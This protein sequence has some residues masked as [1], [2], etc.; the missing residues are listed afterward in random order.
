MGV[1][2]R[3]YCLLY[4]GDEDKNQMIALS[5]LCHLLPKKGS[6]DVISYIF[7]K[8]KVGACIGRMIEHMMC[9]L[10]VFNDTTIIIALYTFLFFR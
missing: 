9:L 1:Q 5:L 7:E 4:I 2:V 6:D 3:D 10:S 8:C